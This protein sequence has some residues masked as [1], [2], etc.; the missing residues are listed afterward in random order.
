MVRFPGSGTSPE[1]VTYDQCSRIR[2]S[3]HLGR[4]GTHE[5]ESMRSSGHEET[6]RPQLTLGAAR[7]QCRKG[8]D[9]KSLHLQGGG[10]TL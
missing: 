10:E 3:A 2:E 4:L 6:R 1:Q 9:A 5:S 7:F 8:R